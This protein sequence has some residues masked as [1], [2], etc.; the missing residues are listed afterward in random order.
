MKLSLFLAK[1]LGLYM[2]VLS[3]GL[4]IHAKKMKSILMDSMDS[5]PLLL[6]SGVIALIVG[7]LI[8]ISHNMWASD[9]RVLITII[10]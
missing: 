10:G 4:L 8:V 1:V 6:V 2:T 3:I 7:L 9:W 5:P